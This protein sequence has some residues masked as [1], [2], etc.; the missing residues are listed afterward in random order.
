MLTAVIP[1]VSSPCSSDAA[2]TSRWAR[3]LID[4]PAM[5]IGSMWSSLAYSSRVVVQ[6]DRHVLCTAVTTAF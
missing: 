5:V 4:V 3:A 2:D 6:T 1:A